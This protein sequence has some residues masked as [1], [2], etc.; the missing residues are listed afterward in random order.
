MIVRELPTHL[1]ISLLCDFQNIKF[2]LFK[3]NLKQ[4]GFKIPHFKFILGSHEEGE[5]RATN[6]LFLTRYEIKKDS[7]FNNLEGIDFR[8]IFLASARFDT[9]KICKQNIRYSPR[10]VEF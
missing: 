7:R 2:N 4:L 3:R 8:G 10:A 9:P 1:N 6:S 5:F